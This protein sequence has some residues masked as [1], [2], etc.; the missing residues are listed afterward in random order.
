MQRYR[1]LKNVSKLTNDLLISVENNILIKFIIKILS[2]NTSKIMLL[3]KY[4]NKNY[5][6]FYAEQ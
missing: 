5:L 1:L 3:Q 4:D 6:N 2:K